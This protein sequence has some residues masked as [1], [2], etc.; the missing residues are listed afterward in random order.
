MK[1]PLHIRF[2]D[3]P[4]SDAIEAEIRKR[5]EKLD[6]FCDH[7]M[8]CEVT[9]STSGKHRGQ[10]RLYE[11]HIDMTVSGTEIVINRVHRHEDVFV[12]IR[13]AF[14][15]AVRKLQDFVREQ[16]ADVKVHETP[17]HGR[18]TKIFTEG[19]GFI[20]TPDGNEFYFNRDNLAYPEFDE[21]QIGMEVQ[22]LTQVAGE[23]LQAKRVSA[24]RHH[25]PGMP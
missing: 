2:I 17:L 19:Y 1:I 16:R 25:I 9:V 13:D 22:F 12:V 15:A 7:V 10:G 11:V 6:Q 18:V 24:G 20:E 14:E 8:H 21:L 23:G 3:I 4:R 5:A